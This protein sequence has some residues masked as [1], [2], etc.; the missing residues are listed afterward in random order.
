MF[1]LVGTSE[2]RS[3]DDRS[4]SRSFANDIG[5]LEAVKHEMGNGLQCCEDAS[6]Y[7]RSSSREFEESEADSTYE[8]DED[9]FVPEPRHVLKVSTHG[10]P[11]S[12][13]VHF[14]KVH[15]GCHVCTYSTNA[16]V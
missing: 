15:V 1:F 13:L 2:F 4:C 8:D 6:G 7:D 5:L 16:S 12:V 3:G 11:Q 14:E 10:R 9:E